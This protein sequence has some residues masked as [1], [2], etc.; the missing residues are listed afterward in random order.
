MPTLAVTRNLRPKTLCGAA[1]AAMILSA[2]SAAC[3]SLHRRVDFRAG[4]L[5]D[6]LQLGGSGVVRPRGRDAAFVFLSGDGEGISRGRRSGS[7][8]RHGLLGPRHQPAPQSIDSTISS[9]TAEA[10]MGEHRKG[11]CHEPADAARTRLDRRDG[12][13]LSGLRHGRPADPQRAIRVGHVP[14]QARS[15]KHSRPQSPSL[16]APARRPSPCRILAGVNREFAIRP[17]GLP[18]GEIGA[19]CFP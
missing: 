1:T 17:Q 15:F 4:A 7:A 9:R 18:N 2:P 12:H 3:G 8:V 19:T 13:V 16:L 11:T 10:R 14:S 6:V 5:R